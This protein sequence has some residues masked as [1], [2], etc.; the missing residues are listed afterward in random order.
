[1][2]IDEA[3][4]VAH[5]EGLTLPTLR[6]YGWDPAALSIGYFQRAGQEVD[7]ERLYSR[8]VGFVRRP[9]GGRAVLHDRELTYSIVVSESYPGIP[10]G[11]EE[12]CRVLSEGLLQGF[13]RLGL[14]ARMSGGEGRNGSTP[15]K[16]DSSAC[17]DAPSRYELIWEGRKIA[18]SSQ[19]RAK[20]AILQHGS[21]PLELDADLLFDVLRFDDEEDKLRKKRIF[22]HKAVAIGDCLRDKNR[23]PVTIPKLEEAFLA[24]FCQGLAADL[25]PG[26]LTVFEEEL[27]AELV[28]AKYARDDWNLRR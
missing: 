2:A 13:R 22:D 23:A 12:A 7:L 17:F 3:M 1:M 14:D 28:S 9:T 5:Q 15:A 18:G 6:F 16:P 19:M 26:A 20:G 24:G 10:D 27:A 25:V 11:V 21:I 8:G 4:F